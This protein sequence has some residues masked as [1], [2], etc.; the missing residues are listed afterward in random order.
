MKI[1]ELRAYIGVTKTLYLVMF[2]NL[3]AAQKEVEKLRNIYTK[4]EIDLFGKISVLSP[5]N[6]RF[7]PIAEET[8]YFNTTE[9]PAKE[10]N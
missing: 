1:Y 9:G 5:S 3:E 8:L 7:E 6:G 10:I 2:T 4:N